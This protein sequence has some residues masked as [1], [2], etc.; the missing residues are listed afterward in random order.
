MMILVLLLNVKNLLKAKIFWKLTKSKKSDLAKAKKLD[1]TNK[2]SGT[3][4]LTLEA[5]KEFNKLQK[6]F[7]EV[8]ITHYFDLK[9][10]IWIETDSFGYVIDKVLS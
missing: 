9:S 8:P 3:D 1:P 7:I 4:F 10:H 6:T 5:Q 2:V